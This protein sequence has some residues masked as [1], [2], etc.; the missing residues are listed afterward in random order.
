[1]LVACVDDPTRLEQLP[2]TALGFRLIA[3][4]HMQQAGAGPDAVE[5]GVGRQAEL[6]GVKQAQK[7]SDMNLQAAVFGREACQFGAG[8]ERRDLITPILERPGITPRA[9]P[10]IQNALACRDLLQKSR[11]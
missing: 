5:Q 11:V 3:P 1:M 6:G 2:Q 9:T 4:G 10:C 7:V 8:I